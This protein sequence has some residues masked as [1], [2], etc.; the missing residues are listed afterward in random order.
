MTI[1]GY[2]E[3]FIG[4]EAESPMNLSDE[5]SIA[6]LTGMNMTG[7]EY[8]LYDRQ[9]STTNPAQSLAIIYVRYVDKRNHSMKHR[10]YIGNS[11]N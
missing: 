2:S 11:F 8:I 6:K 4:T 5:N 10:K 1:G 7:T 9:A 3:Y